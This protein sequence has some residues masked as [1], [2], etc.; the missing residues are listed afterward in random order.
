[1]S[2]LTVDDHYMVRL[3]AHRAVV[4]VTLDG[5]TEQATLGGWCTMHRGRRFRTARIRYA[6]GRMRTVPAAAI[7]WG[8]T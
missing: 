7:S 3:A 1:M 4:T 5:R 6:N 8:R 2:Q